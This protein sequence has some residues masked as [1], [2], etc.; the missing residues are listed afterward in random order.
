MSYLTSFSRIFYLVDKFMVEVGHLQLTQTSCCLIDVSA[1]KV[2]FEQQNDLLR[3]VLDR[4]DAA[5]NAPDV[6]QPHEAV[7]HGEERRGALQRTLGLL[8]FHV[9]LVGLEELWRDAII[10][11]R[12]SNKVSQDVGR[13]RRVQNQ[14]RQLTQQIVKSCRKKD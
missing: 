9:A 14:V 2:L 6:V 4:A 1:T 5:T 13:V 12:T 10:S 3:Q 7:L 11:D 8:V